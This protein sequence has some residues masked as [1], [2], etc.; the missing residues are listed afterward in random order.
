MTLTNQ[1]A[2]GEI[3]QAMMDGMTMNRL[4]SETAIDFVRINQG[5]RDNDFSRKELDEIGNSIFRWR[6][7]LAIDNK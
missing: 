4:T 6:K 2:P 1:T 3:R 5:M 7:W